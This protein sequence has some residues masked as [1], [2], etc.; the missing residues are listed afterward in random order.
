MR[1]GF[2]ITR[3]C[4]FIVLVIFFSSAAASAQPTISKV[5]TPNTIGPGSVSTATF[6]ITNGSAT[7][8]TN[9]SFTDTLPLVPGAMTI[10]DP[11]NASTSCD[12]SSGGSLSA[13]DGGGTITLSDAQLG[14]LSSCTVTVDVTAGTPGVHTN[15]AIT[16][17]SSAGTSQSLPIDLTV[18]TSLPGFS[19][20]F[21]PSS[22]PLG[23]RSTLTFTMDNTL[24][25]SR[26]GNL[27]FTDMLPTG[28]L[29]ADPANASTDCISA[30]AP[31]TTITAY[32]GTNVITLDAIGSTLFP[33]FE[34]LPAGGTCTVTVDVTASGVGTLDNISGDLLSDFTSTG[35]ASDTLEATVTPLSIQKSFTDDPTPP[36]NVVTLEFTIGN[37]NRSSSA[38]AVA[39]TDDLTTLVPAMAGL[40]FD[41]LLF[42][43]CGGSVSGVGGTTLG[44]T[45]GTVPAEGSCTIRTSLSVP[46]GATPGSYTNTTSAVTATVGGSPVVGNAASD[47]LFVEPIP[48]LTKEFLEVGTLAPDPVVTPGDDVVL[49]FTIANPSTTS[50]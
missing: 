36:G 28:M 12:L 32:P 31:N 19:K 49:R 2:R 27:D 39:F 5:F 8:V 38:T 33:G 37:F 10:A 45:G 23:G 26:V 7:P 3:S 11:A 13:P 6:T 29:V 4:L 22:I 50:A 43:D 1:R 34:V 30:G 25:P 47:E 15:P 42:N 9:L 46:A 40:T 41:S 48:V 14:G 21:A 17:S 44:L 24:N 20:S 18:V 16:L 35:K